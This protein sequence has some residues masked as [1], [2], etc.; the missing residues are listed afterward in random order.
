MAVSRQLTHAPGD[1]VRVAEHSYITLSYLALLFPRG[2]PN[3]LRQR[4]E[5]NP[6]DTIERWFRVKIKDRLEHVLLEIYD[7]CGWHRERNASIEY[8]TADFLSPGL[9]ASIARSYFL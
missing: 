7:R 5:K 3:Q 6:V 4:L 2:L 1:S 9:W 8:N